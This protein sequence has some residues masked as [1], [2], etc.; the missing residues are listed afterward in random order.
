[1]WERE[2]RF[3]LV[4]CVPQ[5]SLPASLA[6][7]PCERPVWNHACLGLRGGS[8]Y[9]RPA[10]STAATGSSAAVG[11][12]GG[13]GSVCYTTLR[14]FLPTLKRQRNVLLLLTQ[15]PTP[16]AAGGA[17]GSQP[18]GVGCGLSPTQPPVLCSS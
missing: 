13:S 17:G 12:E 9:V 15:L 11:M 7:V 10:V 2:E 1:M 6:S 8:A 18:T 3:E 5:T 16:T 4:F 14:R